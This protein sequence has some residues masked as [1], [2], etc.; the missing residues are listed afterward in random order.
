MRNP[1]RIHE[2]TLRTGG[3]LVGLVLLVFAGMVLT[4]CSAIKDAGRSAGILP[5]P[6]P[7]PCRV[8]AAQFLTAFDALVSEWDDANISA[9]KTGRLALSGPGG[10]SYKSF[11]E[12][13]DLP[14]PELRH[15]CQVCVNRIH[16]RRN[17]RV[18]NFSCRRKPMSRCGERC[19][20]QRNAWTLHCYS[21]RT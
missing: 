1:P 13:S 2:S 14:V 21:L 7:I 10:G 19:L 3:V 12:L 4:G 17:R 5:T 9:T 8:Q 6:T 20:R 16:E 15:A 18:M 11:G